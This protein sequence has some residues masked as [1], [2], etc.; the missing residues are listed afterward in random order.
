MNYG[1]GRTRGSVFSVTDG[2]YNVPDEHNGVA[3]MSG[4]LISVGRAPPI[5]FPDEHN[6]VAAYT[7]RRMSPAS[8]CA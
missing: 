4:T 5:E 8:M 1:Q 3:V 6:G 7:R 2:W